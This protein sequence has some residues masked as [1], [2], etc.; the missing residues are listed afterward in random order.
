MCFSKQSSAASSNT[1]SPLEV[2]FLVT[3]RVCANSS[4][5]SAI[6]LEGL[7]PSKDLQGQAQ[8]LKFWFG[9]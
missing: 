9:N 4:L 2:D 1:N 6:K 3:Y 8:T 7:Y 5:S